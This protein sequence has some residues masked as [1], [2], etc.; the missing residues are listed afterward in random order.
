MERKS[1][2]VGILIAGLVVAG[3]AGATTAID[4]L[5]GPG[6]LEVGVERINDTHAAVSWTT[7]KPANGILT[8][9][10]QFRC[11]G[12]W[13]AVNSINDSSFSRS[14]LVVA[15]IYDLNKSQVKATLA[16]IPENVAKKYRGVPPKQYKVTAEVYEDGS[17]AS[18]EIIQRNLS[19]TCQ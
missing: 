8:T 15:P 16:D 17:G 13:T 6:S 1:V 2:V 14:H 11:S 4:R 18:K 12:S 7:E 19:Q 5:N 10:V 9:Y 3:F